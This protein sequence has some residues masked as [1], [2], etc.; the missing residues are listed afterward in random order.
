MNPKGKKERL[1]FE[2][3]GFKEEWKE[4]F[5]FIANAEGSPTCLFCNDKLSNKTSNLELLVFQEKHAKFAT[6]HTFG[7]ERKSAIAVLVEKLKHHKNSFKKWIVSL[8]SINALS[9]V[10]TQEIKHGK[11]PMANT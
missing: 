3:R 10:A 11:P 5:A 4:L 2:N 1:L 9:S 8:N 7:T 6:K